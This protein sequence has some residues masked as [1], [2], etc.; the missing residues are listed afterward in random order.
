MSMKKPTLGLRKN[1]ESFKPD[2]VTLKKFKS[3]II[4]LGVLSLEPS[5]EVFV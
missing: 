1:W 4:R 5:S 3:A 2:S